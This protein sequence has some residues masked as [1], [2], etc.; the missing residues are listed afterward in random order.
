LPLMYL[1]MFCERKRK[2]V[3]KREKE[4]GTEKERDEP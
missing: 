3:R 2:K 4:E 1:A